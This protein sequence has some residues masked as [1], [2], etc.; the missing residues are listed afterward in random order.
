M[1]TVTHVLFGTVCTLAIFRNR[2]APARELPMRL[3]VAGTAAA[4]PDIDYLG[5]WIDPLLFLADWHRTATHSLLLMPLW[6]G[7]LALPW[8]FS[9]WARREWLSVYALCALGISSQILLDLLTVFGI[10]LFYPLSFSL[11]AIG[12]SFVIDWIVTVLLAATLFY[13]LHHPGRRVALSG[14]LLLSLYLGSQWGLRSHAHTIVAERL[15]EAANLQLLPQPFSP[16]YWQVINRTDNGY[17]VAYLSLLADR[18]AFIS[19][20]RGADSLAWR[21]ESLLGNDRD[22]AA[23]IEEAWRQPRFLK[24]REFA[25]FPILY[26]LDRERDETCVWFTDLRYTLPYM[27]PAFRYGMCRQQE[28]GWLLYRLKRFTHNDRQ[29]LSSD[30]SLSNRIAP[31]PLSEKSETQRPHSQSYYLY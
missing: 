11:Y 3:A 9:P 28:R 8:M 27:T 5:F 29:R 20:Y 10:R 26:R 2:S 23:L 4:F 14:L 19:H 13:G 16:F 7:V 22:N 31:S 30:K 24:F 15:P 21:K 6:A 17:E 18:E 12:T 1:D 25:R